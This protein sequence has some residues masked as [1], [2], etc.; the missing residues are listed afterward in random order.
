MSEYKS[1]DNYVTTNEAELDILTPLSMNSDDLDKFKGEINSSPLSS[2]PQSSQ[3]ILENSS[4]IDHNAEFSQEMPPS[5]HNQK[6]ARKK[7]YKKLI[8]YIIKES[9]TILNYV[10]S[11]NDC[12][13]EVF[14]L[15][16][17][18]YDKDSVY[19]YYKSLMKFPHINDANQSCRWTNWVTLHY[20]GFHSVWKDTIKWRR[21]IMAL[22]EK[23][24]I[25]I[26]SDG[27]VKRFF[28]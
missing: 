24:L 2:Q 8:K 23:K 18:I 20:K 17:H 4:S 11:E 27:N 6:V 22:R 3:S 5:P 19:Y 1:R 12:D 13:P 10:F 7:K 15:I 25:S 14:R 9:S 21:L 28:Q 16:E 26:D